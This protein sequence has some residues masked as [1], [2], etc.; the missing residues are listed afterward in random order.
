MLST[1]GITECKDLLN[2][3]DRCNYPRI[4]KV[5]GSSS[6][7]LQKWKMTLEKGKIPFK[8]KNH[9]SYFLMAEEPFFSLEFLRGQILLQNVPSKYTSKFSAHL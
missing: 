6:T 1:E 5:G 3:F 8:K 9:R 2:I 4:H 7:R